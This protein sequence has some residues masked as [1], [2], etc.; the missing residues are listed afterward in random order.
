ML[1][2]L[3]EPEIQK[4]MN[5][6]NKVL[7]IFSVFYDGNE[8]F[9]YRL[10]DFDYKLPDSDG[11]ILISGIF[12]VFITSIILIGLSV[13]YWQ[14]KKRLRKTSISSIREIFLC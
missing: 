1:N 9:T 12:G 3:N 6:V 8:F 11:S 5:E 13:L 14:F 2:N 10:N 4:I 7:D